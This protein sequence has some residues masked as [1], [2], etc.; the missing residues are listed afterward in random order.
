MGDKSKLV[1]VGTAE[2]PVMVPIHALEPSSVDGKEYWEGIASGSIG[3]DGDN[4]DKLLIKV[5]DTKSGT[6]SQS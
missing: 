3:L 4:L 5:D 1:N 6:G 2:R